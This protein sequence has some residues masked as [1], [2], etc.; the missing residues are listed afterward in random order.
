MH[1]KFFLFW[2]VWTF[3]LYKCSTK[4]TPFINFMK[5]INNQNLKCVRNKIK[6][7]IKIS[8]KMFSCKPRLQYVL[9]RFLRHNFRFE[10]I[11]WLNFQIKFQKIK[12]Y[13]NE[14]NLIKNLKCT[15]FILFWYVWA[16]VLNT[17]DTKPIPA[18]SLNETN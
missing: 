11:L 1:L 4:P 10:T 13:N 17:C 16:F 14:F 9:F 18:I 12:K 6:S 3:M 15:Y 5:R 7:R 2:Y 8:H